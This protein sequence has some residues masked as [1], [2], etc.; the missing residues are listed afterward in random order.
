M[1]LST[2]QRTNLMN[3]TSCSQP[4]PDIYF[5]DFELGFDHWFN[6][7]KLCKFGN[8]VC[9]YYKPITPTLWLQKKLHEN[10]F[11]II[12]CQKIRFY[13]EHFNCFDGSTVMD[14]MVLVDCFTCDL[15]NKCFEKFLENHSE[16]P[17]METF[18][19]KIQAVHY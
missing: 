17:A 2:G 1:Y 13:E 7:K 16:I 5:N 14:Q 3:T 4:P 19:S 8:L 15:L 11:Q 6:D 10:S 18:V 9:Y 12:D